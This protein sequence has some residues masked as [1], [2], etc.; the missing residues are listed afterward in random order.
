VQTPCASAARS[1]L[2]RVSGVAATAGAVSCRKRSSAAA[3]AAACS[4]L[5]DGAITWIAG[6]RGRRFPFVVILVGYL[7]LRPS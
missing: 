7:G 5:A 3:M 6:L 1:H 2:L 4:G